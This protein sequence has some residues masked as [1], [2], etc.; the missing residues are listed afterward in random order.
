MAG[1][2]LVMSIPPGPMRIPNP[3]HLFLRLPICLPLAGRQLH[4]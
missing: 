3:S 4:H 2:G 1:P